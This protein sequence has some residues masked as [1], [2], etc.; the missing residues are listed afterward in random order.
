MFQSAQPNSSQESQPGTTQTLDA[1]ATPPTVA[2][3]ALRY[4]RMFIEY[5]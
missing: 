5:K 2:S 1:S 4:A 3:S